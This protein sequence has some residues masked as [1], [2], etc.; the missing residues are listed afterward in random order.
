MNTI[1]IE[2]EFVSDKA[3]A[4][5]LSISPRSFAELVRRGDLKAI[6]VPGMRRIVYD[7]ADIRA[8]AAR[9]RAIER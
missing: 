5:M 3:G 8:L 2:P 6:K 9:W 7:V 1:A 4:A